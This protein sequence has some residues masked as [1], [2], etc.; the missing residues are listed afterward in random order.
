M[1]LKF[2]DSLK[3]LCCK[4]NINV[5]YSIDSKSCLTWCHNFSHDLNTRVGLGNPKSKF[6]LDVQFGCG[7]WQ[8]LTIKSDI[9]YRTQQQGPQ[10][11]EKL[12]QFRREPVILSN[13]QLE[14]WPQLLELSV[15]PSE[16][17]ATNS[18][19]SSTTSKQVRSS[20]LS[21]WSLDTLNLKSVNCKGCPSF[22]IFW[23]GKHLSL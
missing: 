23:F 9:C 17:P 15:I 7:V 10:Y 6:I 4:T 19:S 14:W 8:H 16:F 5:H 20:S 12:T 18:Q 1:W 3:T 11:Q 2:N 21:S 22:I 13:T